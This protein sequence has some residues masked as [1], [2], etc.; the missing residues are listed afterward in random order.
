MLRRAIPFAA[1]FLALTAPA[2]A[3]AKTTSARVVECKGADAAGG[4]SATFLGRMRA[5]SPTDVMM[6]RFTLL[7]QFGD[8]KLHPV[9]APELR[10]WRQ[11][12]PG[13]K[14][15]RYR[16]TVTALQGG[17][18]YRMR[19]EFRWLDSAGNLVRKA[20]KTTSPCVQK[21]PLANL[22]ISAVSAQPGAAGTAVYLLSMRN[23]G[24]LAATDVAVELFVDGAATNV[25][26]I[27]AIAP[28]QTREAR[29]T[30]PLCKRSLRAVADPTDAVKER[31]ESDN[32]L[33]VKCPSPGA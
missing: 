6:M 26:H 1:L 2:G 32:A 16:Q 28:G 22:E 12:K 4:R 33:Q 23:G 5:M 19:V 3:V 9:V 14:E 31:F 18:Q 10:A 15:F 29:F 27:D 30:G 20:Q 13:V 21:G 25:G 24:G 17:G 11:S 8:E 7:E